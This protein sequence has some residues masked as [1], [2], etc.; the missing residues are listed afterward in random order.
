MRSRRH[1]R[2][3][4]SGGNEAFSSGRYDEAIERYTEAM[5]VDAKALEVHLTL[6]T[7]RA[8]AKFKLQNYKGAIDDCNAALKIQPRH[9]KVH[10]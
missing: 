2:S 8:T 1:R 7:N 4:A 9:V 10:P 3:A 6:Y 5:E